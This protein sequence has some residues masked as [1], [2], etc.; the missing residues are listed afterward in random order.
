MSLESYQERIKR[1]VPKE[2]DIIY[3][4]EGSIGLATFIPLDK[5]ICLGQRVMLFRASQAITAAYLKYTVTDI[6]YKNR[7]LS[8]HR[9]M[10][11][12]HVNVKDIVESLIALPPIDEQ[13][14]IVQKLEELMQTCNEL[15]ESIKLSASQNEK[16]LQQVLREAL[17]QPASHPER[18]RREAG[19][20]EVVA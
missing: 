10:G 3:A 7:L 15:E 13:K 4:R 11:A 6:G 14:R 20:D 16:L 5:N 19:K 9:G 12:K 1:L 8:K 17:S 18:S 2:N